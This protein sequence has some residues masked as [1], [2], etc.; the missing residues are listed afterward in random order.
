MLAAGV[1]QKPSGYFPRQVTFTNLALQGM[2]LQFGPSLNQP[3][4]H[5]DKISNGN[6][7]DNW[8]SSSS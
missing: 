1:D 4:G 3:H 2:S 5:L 7:V 6:R 8:G